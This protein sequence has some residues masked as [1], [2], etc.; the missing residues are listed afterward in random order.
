MRKM[1]EGRKKC[2][3][4]QTSFLPAENS[5]ESDISDNF[6]VRRIS[7]PRLIALR[8]SLRYDYPLNPL[9]TTS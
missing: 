3:A 4:G 1:G 7:S 8:P 2:S 5:D 9:N 6:P